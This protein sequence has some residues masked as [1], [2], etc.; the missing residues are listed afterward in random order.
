M[1]RVEL[2]TGWRERRRASLRLRLAA[3]VGNVSFPVAGRIHAGALALSLLVL[4]GAAFAQQALERSPAPIAERKPA[5]IRIAEP[6]YGTLDDTPLGV[7]VS[8]I[9]LIGADEAVGTSNP[10]GITFGAIGEA[11]EAALRAA[12]AP[13]LGKPLSL[14]L[15]AGMQAAVAQAW[16]ETGHP[17]VSVTAPPQEITSGVIRLRVIEARMG[18]TS[19]SGVDAERGDRLLQRV[20][21][22]E[23]GDRISAPQIE[24]GLD[25]LNRVPQRDVTAVF[26][27]GAQTGTT[28]LTLNVSEAR[29]VRIFAGWDNTG[30]RA[31]DRN[32]I[33][34]GAA[35]WVPGLNDLT[36]SYRMTGSP[37]LWSKLSRIAPR[38]GDFA[39]Y[40]SHAGRIVLPTLPLQSLEISPGFIATREEPNALAA[41]ESTT[42]ELPVIYRTAISNLVPGAFAGDVYG[43]AEFKRARRTTFFAG[44]PVARGEAGLFQLVLG[45]SDTI[46]DQHGV[47]SIDLSIHGNPGG[48]VSGNDAATWTAFSGGSVTDVT[49]AYAALNASRTTRLGKGFSWISQV[50][51]TIAGQALP[52]TERMALGGF[53][54]TRG[55][56]V[57]DASVDSGVVWRNE[58]RLPPVSL[59]GGAAGGTDQLSAFAFADLGYGRDIAAGTSTTLGGAGIGFDYAVDDWFGAKLVAGW[60][61]AN[62]AITRAGD[63]RL[64]AMATARY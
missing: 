15:V 40:L 63:F 33:F 22:P 61:L 60:A 59:A 38:E 28:D 42:F 13:Y 45:W 2:E 58:L 9:R 50:S 8:G 17:F 62:G 6:D 1:H 37:D 31:T 19:V 11:P 52:Q 36:V 23:K 34:A 43:G 47:T 4:P 10:A 64:H 56:G 29:P 57:D 12:L 20:H 5:S 54:A 3:G 41:F 27:P 7:N 32:R 24:E 44:V 48:V 21:L 35:I 51:A 53:A 30:A 49:Y 55:Y 16:R 25:W 46:S 39:S 14:S 26:S 18:E